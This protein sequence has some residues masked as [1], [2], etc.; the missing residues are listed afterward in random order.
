[1]T[2]KQQQRRT[3]AAL[4]AIPSSLWTREQTRQAFA[5]RSAL[6]TPAQA[7]RRA[8]GRIE[9]MHVDATRAYMQNL[10]R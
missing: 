1:M 9:S 6:T 4:E 8:A 7:R 10:S 5:L 2:H 3:L